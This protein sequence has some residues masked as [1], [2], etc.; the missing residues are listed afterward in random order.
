MTLELKT[1]YHCQSPQV[2]QFFGAFFT[3]GYIYISLVYFIFYFYFYLFYFYLFFS[4]LFFF[5]VNFVFSKELMD[6]GSLG[7]LLKKAGPFPEDAIRDIAF[8]VL[9]FFFFFFFFFK[10]KKIF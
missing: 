1:L 8:Q 5:L 3:E 9:F 7:D 10:K 2:V 4:F 6:G